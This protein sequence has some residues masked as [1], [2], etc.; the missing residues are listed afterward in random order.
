M[1]TN[2]SRVT[3]RI[4][5][6]SASSRR[7]ISR[8]SWDTGSSVAWRW[9]GAEGAGVGADG[10]ASA[11]THR[12]G[13]LGGADVDEAEPGQRDGL[14][15]HQRRGVP[16]GRRL[17]V[18]QRVQRDLLGEEVEQLAPGGLLLCRVGARQPLVEQALHLF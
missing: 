18:E 5:I 16:G 11:P 2:T 6:G 14:E 13:G 17:A 12:S 8:T 4:I 1:M 9:A 15:V 10:W 7:P 3:P